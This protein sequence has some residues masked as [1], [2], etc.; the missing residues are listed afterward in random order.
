MRSA[1]GCLVL[2]EPESTWEAERFDWERRCGSDRSVDEPEKVCESHPESLEGNSENPLV[3]EFDDDKIS[4][5]AAAF[6]V[7]G[8]GRAFE[9]GSMMT[10]GSASSGSGGEL[11]VSEAEGGGDA[12]VSGVRCLRLKSLLVFLGIGFDLPL[13]LLSPTT[14]GDDGEGGRPLAAS[15]WAGT[16]SGED[17]DRSR[18]STRNNLFSL[19]GPGD[20]ERPEGGDEGVPVE[21]I[22]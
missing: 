17:L 4:T 2:G 13:L 12:G 8:R 11:I 6:F 5:A 18:R 22:F 16:A 1:F 7:R 19:D 10:G 15:A 9:G 21:L 20:A 3:D 14:L